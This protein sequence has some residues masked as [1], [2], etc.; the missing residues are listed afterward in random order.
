MALKAQL[1]QVKIGW[2]FDFPGLR[3]SEQVMLFCKTQPRFWKVKL[4]RAKGQTISTIVA[5][6][7]VKS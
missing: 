2:A 3:A 6:T 1:D 5:M 7:I 4:A